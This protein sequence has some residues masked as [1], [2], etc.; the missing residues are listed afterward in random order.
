MAFP[1][2][3]AA[4]LFR[5]VLLLLPVTS[6]EV[7]ASELST[8]HQL[9][10]LL[11]LLSQFRSSISMHNTIFNYQI[12]SALNIYIHVYRDVVV[13]QCTNLFVMYD[14]I[15]FALMPIL[16]VTAHVGFLICFIVW[17]YFG[18]LISFFQRPKIMT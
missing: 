7:S 1:K 17:A 5:R 6:F 13:S 18:F 10:C 14:F 16:H 12:D 9:P 3:K 8:Y 15:S 11:K 4:H 2:A